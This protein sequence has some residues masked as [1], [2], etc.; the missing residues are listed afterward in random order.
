VVAP[1][2]DAEVASVAAYTSEDLPV[3]HVAVDLAVVGHA[4][5]AEVARADAGPDLIHDHVLGVDVGELARS[6]A[7]VVD[8]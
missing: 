8:Q 5:E 4:A 7:Q 2:R 6:V 1:Q 3:D